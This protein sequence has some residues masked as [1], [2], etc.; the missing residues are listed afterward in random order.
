M[1]RGQ[2]PQQL[3][4]AGGAIALKAN[5]AY[6]HAACVRPN[7][8]RKVRKPCF[9]LVESSLR[10]FA[11]IVDPSQSGSVGNFVACFGRAAEIAADLENMIFVVSSYY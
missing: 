1:R 4:V 10:A 7:K 11:P 2:L 6:E 8:G 3:A 9:L 5:A